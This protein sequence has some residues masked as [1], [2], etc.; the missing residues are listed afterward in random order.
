MV[1]DV[2]SIDSVKT[3]SK[4]VS[5]FW[6]IES[7]ERKGWDVTEDQGN[8]ASLLV[9]DIMLNENRLSSRCPGLGFRS[10]LA[11]LADIHEQRVRLLWSWICQV[12]RRLQVVSSRK[13]LH[14]SRR[15]SRVGEFAPTDDG[16]PGARLLTLNLRIR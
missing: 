1:D 4:A 9:F 16:V 15:R 14:E 7:L 3:R 10:R 5:K 12:L 11:L 8:E 2:V 6:G 13:M